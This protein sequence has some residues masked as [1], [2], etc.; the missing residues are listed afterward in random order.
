LNGHFNRLTL[1]I[2]FLL[3]S[4]LNAS[5]ETAAQTARKWD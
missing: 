3:A 1:V 4:S 2:V 5:A